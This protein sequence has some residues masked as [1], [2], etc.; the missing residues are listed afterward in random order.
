MRRCFP[1]L[2]DPGVLT[3]EIDRTAARLDALRKSPEFLVPGSEI[4]TE[5]S[6]VSRR[7]AVLRA[8]LAGN[9][10]RRDP[11]RLTLRY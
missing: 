10:G 1:Q 4:E 9:N 2:R 6:R 7:L 5:H 8:E 3:A 11:V